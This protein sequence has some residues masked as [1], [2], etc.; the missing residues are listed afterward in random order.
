MKDW[1]ILVQPFE[2]LDI[3]T[4]EINKVIN[5]HATVQIVG[6]IKEEL[7]D[8]YV[9]MAQTGKW[10]I[11]SAF[12]PMDG[13]TIVFKGIID[14]IS[15]QV[16]N[17]ERKI[18]INGISASCQMDMKKQRQTFQDAN[19]TYQSLLAQLDKHYDKCLAYMSIGR[20][21][22]LSDLIVQ[23]D[24]TDWQF[25]KRLAGHFNSFLVPDY[26]MGDGIK[27]YFGLPN[28]AKED[29]IL[30]S[31]EM[32]KDLSEYRFKTAQ[33]IQEL[34]E[35]DA[36]YYKFMSRE[37]YELGSRIT[38][39]GRALIV[40]AIHSHYNHAQLEHHYTLKTE[41]GLRQPKTYNALL[42]G[43]SING[44]VIDVQNDQVK[45]HTEIDS[46]QPVNQA[47][48]FPY[49]TVYSSPDGAG[50][51]C[52]PEIGDQVRLYF[53][54]SIE[55]NAFVSSSVHL[56]GADNRNDPDLKIWKTK[57]GKE[58]RF[59]PDSI[60]ITNNNGLS[61]EL[62]DA[63]GIKMSSDKSIEIVADQDVSITSTSAMVEISALKKAVIS[64]KG[65]SITIQ[66]DVIFKG[67]K[68][69]IE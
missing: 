47:K 37:I 31:Y 14:Q 43:A 57:Y 36:I 42:T 16:E 9:E 4:L 55:E 29:I 48:W 52:M 20:E 45:V 56:L 1:K 64:Q 63:D 44:K 67:A 59:S 6:R 51:Y 34:R 10:L 50:W 61:I 26:K 49:S 41:S 22:L 5:D 53:P 2:L 32:R 18:T 15:I 13:E 11:V 28:R 33:D 40:A 30:D 39:N 12:D 19:M 66:K 60:L 7:E 24:E 58:M 23:Y 17:R 27:F 21:T 25:L 35:R 54:D 62:S 38:L 46:S 8:E 68:V 65:A 69:K 3:L